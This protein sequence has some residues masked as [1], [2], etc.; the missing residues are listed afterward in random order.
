ME[1]PVIIVGAGVSGLCCAAALQQAGCPVRVLE[2]SDR[3]GGRVCTDKFDGF[4][5]DRG[6]QVLLEAY[7]AVQACLDVPAL[8]AGAFGS[9]AVLF[10]GQR[11]RLFADPLRHPREAWGS[12]THPVGT[13]G[14]KLRLAR[15]RR[16]WRNDSVE[17]LMG[18]EEMSTEAYWRQLG[19]SESMRQGFLAPFFR[20]IF[21]GSEDE[22]SARMFRFIFAMF[23]KGRAL[24]P[25]GGIGRVAEQLAARL[26]PGTIEFGQ[27]VCQVE[28]DGVVIAGERLEASAVIVATGEAGRVGL[29]AGCAAW[30]STTCMYFAAEV[31][32]IEGPWLA[33]NA[34]GRGRVNQVAVPSQVAEGFAPAGQELV[35]V[36]MLGVLD[37][38]EDANVEAVRNELSAWFGDQVQDWR[39]LRSYR[40]DHALPAFAEGALPGPGFRRHDGIW[41]CG[42]AESH[43]SLQGAMASGQRVAADVLASRDSG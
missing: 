25:A 17:D 41:I 38:D 42:D 21:L 5:L 13:L 19:F 6:F 18:M 26:E 7:P 22:V 15:L 39:P 40:V 23:G 8:Q 10:D 32:P 16:S 4:A 2:A 36:S 27:S 30:R 9:G 28:A 1:Q 12:V 14:D 24:L 11:I 3:P 31:S 35:S 43:P 33:L 29:P 20:G 37:G 34:S